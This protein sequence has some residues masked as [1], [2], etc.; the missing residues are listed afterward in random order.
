MSNIGQNILLPAAASYP[1]VGGTLFY[2]PNTAAGD[3]AMTAATT[4]AGAATATNVAASLNAA[5]TGSAYSS[6]AH[7]IPAPA[8]PAPQPDH[9]GSSATPAPSFNGSNHH[10]QQPLH[11]LDPS[12]WV[13]ATQHTTPSSLYDPSGSAYG[14]GAASSYS[15]TYGAP[16]SK[17]GAGG[18]SHNLALKPDIGDEDADA[19]ATGSMFN[20]S[21][22]YSNSLLGGVD[23]DEES[24]YLPGN[25][26]PR[27]RKLRRGSQSESVAGASAYSASSAVTGTG[28]AAGSSR[29]HSKRFVCPHPGCGRAFA[30][31]FNMQS[32]LKSHLGI[33]EFDCPH[34]PKK[35]SRKHDRARH[36]AAV[37]HDKSGF[38][39]AVA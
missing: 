36:C 30:R 1:V 14:G 22:A 18:S 8:P 6:L 39:P 38:D 32:H 37:H 11:Q 5:E 31:N 2:V 28:S 16:A 3:P 13:A 15:Y 4:A 34:C 29:P 27:S 35:F 9:Q 26:A 24:E 12:Q 19:D 25:N 10:Q 33:R 20:G 23:E 17:Y 21:V 7:A